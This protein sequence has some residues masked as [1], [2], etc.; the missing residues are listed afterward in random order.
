M[1]VRSPWP[2]SAAGLL[3]VSVVLA[4]GLRTTTANETSPPSASKG[5]APAKCFNPAAHIPLTGKTCGPI[6]DLQLSCYL[7][8]DMVPSASPSPMKALL[9]FNTLQRSADIFSW[10]EFFA[11]NWPARADMRGEPDT[12]K[13]I[14]DPGPRVWETWKEEY[15]VYLKDGRQPKSWN[16]HE[17]VPGACGAGADKVFFRTQKIDDVV[18]ATMQAA[19]ADGT[20]PSTLTDQKGKLVRYEIRLNKVLFDYVVENRLYNAGVQA[21]A[22]SVNFPNGAILIKAAWREVSP[23]EEKLFHTVTACVCDK[24]KLGR[25]VNCHRQRMGLVGLHITQKTPFAP[26]WVWS[27]FEQVNNVPGFAANGSLSFNN[28]SCPTC[29]VNKQTPRGT[30]NQMTRAIPIPAV[31][32]NCGD[33]TQAVDNVRRLNDDVKKALAGVGSVFEN[34]EL[35]NTQW[36]VPQA[37]DT[38]ETV[39]TVRPLALGNTTMESFVQPTSTCMGCHSTART[40]NANNFVSSDF[41]FTLN[42]AQPQQSNCK[43]I[44]PPAKPRTMWERLHWTKI[45][46]GYVLATQTYELLPTFVPTAKLHCASCHLSAGGNSDAA[47]W[48][49]L[50]AEYPTKPQLQSRINHCFTNSLNGNALCTPASKGDKGNCDTNHDMEA[51][52]IYME[53]LDEQ[54]KHLR[55]CNTVLHGY[56][57]LSCA[58]GNP[59]AGQQV[60]IQK[61]AVCH[62]LDGQGRYESNTYFRP[63]LWGPHSF[64]QAAGMFSDPSFLAAFVR[65]NMPLMA[66]GELTD[67][68]AWDLEAFI[69][70]KDRP[71]T[72]GA[73]K[74]K[75]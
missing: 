44:P 57:Q 69:H 11:L 36:P 42:N 52:L 22:N 2:L 16:D 32:P 28:P 29:P 34:Y 10:Q 25:M 64:N 18:D 20:L 53:W 24:D 60:F 4:V 33:K 54:S 73:K 8:P 38:P 7:P 40:V 71:K 6:P 26:Q 51:F 65:W 13:K 48:I 19:A 43:V 45:M 39:F 58:T 15:E 35:I 67:Q 21:L 31:E 62:G 50:K 12:N 17:P 74:F 66:G 27:T 56:P 63:A 3:I 5:A 37:S 70:S 1:F 75:K 30:P 46:R 23:A 68:E 47:W 9:N 49:N 61:C 41:S 72:P 14:T 59:A 55:L